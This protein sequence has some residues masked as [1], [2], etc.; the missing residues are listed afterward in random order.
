MG[1]LAVIPVNESQSLSDTNLLNL[2]IAAA[3]NPAS[4][5]GMIHQNKVVAEP[6][7]QIENKA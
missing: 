2:N 6:E 4:I 7:K 5:P 3:I 1:P